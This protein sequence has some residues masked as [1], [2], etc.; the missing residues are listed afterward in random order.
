MRGLA[1]SFE[2]PRLV[3]GLCSY[4]ELDWGHAALIV[5]T[6]AWLEGAGGSIG[7]GLR[8]PGMFSRK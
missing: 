8:V 1:R 7:L 6:K 2:P 5:D 3:P 4:N